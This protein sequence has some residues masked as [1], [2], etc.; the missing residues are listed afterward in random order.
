MADP[1]LIADTNLAEGRKLVA[2]R[3]GDGNWTIGVGH[4]L[5][6]RR[7][8]TGFTITGEVSDEYLAEDLAIS[9]GECHGLP[10]WSKLDG[11]PCRQN[12]IIEC[13]FN[14]GLS[15]WYHEFPK[16]RAALVA[17]DWEAASEHLIASPKWVAQVGP[18]RVHR[19]AGY[20]LY[21]DYPNGSE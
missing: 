19:I 5:D 13:V 16:T 4:L 11:N 7:D 20:I 17:E 3:D 2:Y 12:A 8:W 21:G 14:L 9:T 15:H 18:G 10:E 6:Q 1:R